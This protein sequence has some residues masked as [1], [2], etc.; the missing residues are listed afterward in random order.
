V[1]DK[2]FRMCYTDI[3]IGGIM[4]FSELLSVEQRKEILESRILNFAVEAYQVSL[5]KQVAESGE[6]LAAV[7]QANN[8][9]ATLESAIQIYKDELASI[10]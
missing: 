2:L 3:N 7:E 5:N 4:N 10:A 6:D 9:L 1:F 8:A